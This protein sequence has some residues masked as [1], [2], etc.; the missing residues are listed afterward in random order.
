MQHLKILV[1]AELISLPT[2][3]SIS[4]LKYVHFE[5]CLQKTETRLHIIHI[6]VHICVIFL[7]AFFRYSVNFPLSMADRIGCRIAK[8]IVKLNPYSKHY[9]VDEF[10]N[11]ISDCRCGIFLNRPF[12]FV[13]Y[14]HHI[15]SRLL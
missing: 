5:T 6:H 2:C 15:S 7:A 14:H 12:L 8:H 11:C 10:Q 9:P 13:H 3:V 4:F 1:H